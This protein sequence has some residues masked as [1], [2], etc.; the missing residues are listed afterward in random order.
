MSRDTV[1]SRLHVDDAT[2]GA[3]EEVTYRALV[4]AY[5]AALAVEAKK[6]GNEGRVALGTGI[7]L[8]LRERAVVRADI[9]QRAI[10]S[11]ID[12]RLAKQP[13]GWTDEERLTDLRPVLDGMQQ[14]NGTT[15]AITTALWAQ[16]RAKVDFY[17][18]NAPTAEF[19]FIPDD[20]GCERCIE[21]ADGNPYTPEGAGEVEMPVH[22]DCQHGWE[23]E[24]T[25]AFPDNLWL[26]E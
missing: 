1:Y 14:H 8:F 22:N 2:H 12:A 6:R 20:V 9:I 7:L 10:N 11:R 26:G 5:T 16:E 24:Y 18:H 4:L 21:I 19:R 3:I 13:E 23:I 15:L 25:G 17:A